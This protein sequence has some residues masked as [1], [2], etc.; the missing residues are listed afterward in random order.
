MKKRHADKPIFYVCL[1]MSIILMVS[2]FLLPPRG[3]IDPSVLTACGILFGFAALAVA[4][5]NLANGK[6]IE[7][8]KGDTSLTIGDD[9]K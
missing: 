2:G 8:K 7:F 1:S 9:E 6:D 4:A 3:V 5:Q